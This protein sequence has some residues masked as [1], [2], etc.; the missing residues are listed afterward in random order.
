MDKKDLAEFM[1]Y[2]Q[3][4]KDK[5]KLDSLLEKC[6]KFNETAS[7]SSFFLSFP[8]EKYEITESFNFSNKP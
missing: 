3:S 6:R 5:S 8:N 7:Q 1:K 2:A 4:L